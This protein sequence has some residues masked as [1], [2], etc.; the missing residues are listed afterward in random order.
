MGVE[1]FDLIC[2]GCGSKLHHSKLK[3]RQIKSVEFDTNED[4]KRHALSISTEP[5][6]VT[7][8][9][10]ETEVEIEK[11]KKEMRE[12]KRPSDYDMLLYIMQNEDI[13]ANAYRSFSNAESL[14]PAS[15]RKSD[16]EADLP[17]IVFGNYEFLH[18]ADCPKCETRLETPWRGTDSINA[19]K[20]SSKNRKSDSFIKCRAC[21]SRIVITSQFWYIYFTRDEFHEYKPNITTICQKCQSETQ[22]KGN[23]NLGL[24]YIE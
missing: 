5:P 9:L 16:P 2:H 8:H 15:R 7:E 14:T 20:L 11:I 10:L 6:Q 12:G 1:K 23:Y 21:N 3:W 22:Y 24:R 19:S 18:M 13:R 17:Y 4:N